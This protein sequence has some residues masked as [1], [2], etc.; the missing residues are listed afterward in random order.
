M[1]VLDSYLYICCCAGARGGGG[2]PLAATRGRS[3]Y[4]LFIVTGTDRRES[5]ELVIVVVVQEKRG[6]GAR[7]AAAHRSLCCA[8]SRCPRRVGASLMPA[9]CRRSQAVRGHAE[10]A[11]VGGGCAP[12]V[13]ALRHDRGVLHPARAR[14]R[15]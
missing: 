14:R 7:A 5:Y 8:A 12:A 2:R 11:A 10:Q 4:P 9:L 6:A 15:E 13:H 1:C 3:R